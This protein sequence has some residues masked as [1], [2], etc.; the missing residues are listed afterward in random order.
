MIKNLTGSFV[1]TN[2]QYPQQKYEEIHSSECASKKINLWKNDKKSVQLALTS[3]DSH[4]TGVS[5]EVSEFKN[6]NNTSFQGTID[7]YFIQSTQ[8]FDR[9][10]TFSV[11][12]DFEQPPANF[13]QEANEILTVKD[14]IDMQPQSVQNIWLNIS[15]ETDTEPGVYH[16][17]VIIH[18]DLLEHVLS[19]KLT[20]KVIN[21]DV[22]QSASTFDLEFWQNPY[23]SAEYYE[24]VPFSS[25]HFKILKQHMKLY[26]ELS[27]HAITATICEDPWDGQTYSSHQI[28][29]PSMVKWTKLANG[30]WQFDYDHF[31]KWV[32]FNQK[33]GLGDKIV[34]YSIVPWSNQIIYYDEATDQNKTIAYEI[35]D[36]TYKKIWTIF[37]KDFIHHTE[38]NHI[39]HNIHLG[40]DERGFNSVAFELIDQFR[41]SQGQKFKISAAADNLKEKEHFLDDID[42]LT[43]GTVPI[44]EIP[45]Y[46][47]SLV[48]KRQK[49]GLKTTAYS[50]TGHI[51]GNF[52]LSAPGESYWTILFSYLN[53]AEGFLRWAYD[54]WVENPLVDASHRLFE[55]G[56]CFLIYPDKK[57]AKH[58]KPHLTTRLEK[59]IEGI[60]A[61]R[62]IE[63]LS[64]HLPEEHIKQHLLKK[65]NFHYSNNEI[66]LDEKG[67]QQL[68]CDLNNV[69]TMIH[70]YSVLLS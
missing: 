14:K 23:A 18:T 29:F 6:E 33:L 65:I 61:V 32:A 13:R 35:G 26:K 40:V 70:D 66:Y 63:Y 7:P 60:Q 57:S 15:S 38:T 48:R 62:K 2:L 25:E 41:N 43:V 51:P 20:I 30:E 68:V 67:K 4:V 27:G 55:A 17:E 46:Y 3:I 8:A 34:C 58:P 1:D 12:N 47:A 52:A 50:C 53:G 10:P 54:S 5:M 19:F 42:D 64:K 9:K 36:R 24:V 56:D 31:D 49:K 44:K 45:D 28:K 69:E 39:F 22:N 16:G 21:L 59:M 37:L 11:Y